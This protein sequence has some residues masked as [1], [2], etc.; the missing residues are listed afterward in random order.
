MVSV[1]AFV[2]SAAVAIA[3]P[4][5]LT[6]TNT[7]RMDNTFVYTGDNDTSLKNSQVLLTTVSTFWY[8]SIA[9]TLNGSSVSDRHT[10]HVYAVP[11]EEY[12]SAHVIND[13]C[14]R[15]SF[16]PPRSDPGLQIQYLYAHLPFHYNGCITNPIENDD[17]VEVQGVIFRL[18]SKKEFNRYE[19]YLVD[20]NTSHAL[21]TTPVVS[22]QP[23]KTKCVYLEIDI[24]QTTFYYVTMFVSNESVISKHVSYS[25]YTLKQY[26]DFDRKRHHPICYLEAGKVCAYNLY[27]GS[28]IN[29]QGKD[30]AIIADVSR[31]SSVHEPTTT[32]TVLSSRNSNVVDLG[33]IISVVIGVVIMIIILVLLIIACVKMYMSGDHD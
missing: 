25:C 8:K 22:V 26:R 27:N 2:V 12:H 31:S 15:G 1:V 3:P 24:P 4:L 28:F 33:V 32:I 21:K 17:S 14:A 23:G 7:D 16:H 11:V 10:A 29:T 19:H 9:V 5:S 6:L 18:S 20:G 13:T 30:L